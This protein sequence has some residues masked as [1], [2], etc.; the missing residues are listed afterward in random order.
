MPILKILKAGLIGTALLTACGQGAQPDTRSFSDVVTEDGLAGIPA[1]IATQDKTAETAYLSGMSE[2]LLAIE[3]VLQVRYD[4]Y[5][6]ELPMVPGGQADIAYNPDAKFD[7]AFVET[8]MLGALDHFA[9][10]ERALEGAIGKDFAVEVEL[11]ELWFDVDRDGK[12]GEGE[13]ALLQIGQLFG[14]R[15]GVEAYDGETVI[16]FDTADADWLAAYVNVASASAELILSVDPTSAIRAIFEG[17]KEIAGL[18]AAVN[19]SFFGDNRQLDTLAVVLTA[20]DGT[21]DPERTR[22]ALAHLKKMISHNENFWTLVEQETDDN[23]EWLPNANQV[24]A[25]GVEVTAETAMA[26]RAVLSEMSDLLNGR[27]LVPHWR[28]GERGETGHGLNIES[29]LTDPGDFDL[30]LMLHGASLAPHFEYGKLV[31]QS[32]WRDFSL[33]VGGRGNIFALW[34]N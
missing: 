12:R 33:T 6:G 9:K 11:K 3:H 20:L 21:P 23:R 22:A 24:S 15:S 17:N 8:A 27:K 5:S 13:A 7:P 18:G 34:L 14:E 26:W 28:F 4:T 10:A 29:L 30:V 31:N 16:R 32:V 1:W 2:A 25:F 19:P